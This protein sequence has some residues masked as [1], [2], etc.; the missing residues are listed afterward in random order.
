V[1]SRPW[2]LINPW[3]GGGTA[4]RVRLADA[5]R[6]AGITVHVLSRGED[7]T[8]L[9]RAAVRAGAD[10]LGVAGG[11]GSLGPIAA[12]AIEADVPFVCIPAGT[13]NHFA[14]DLGL[15][16]ADPIGALAAFSGL[17]RWIDTAMVGDRVFLN[18]VSIGAYADV[19]AQ[20][21][22]RERKLD[23]ARV[24]LRRIVRGE[25]PAAAI[26]FRDPMGTE[27]RNVAL[28]MVANNA[29]ALRRAGRFGTRG[30]L[31]AGALQVSVLRTRSGAGLARALLGALTAPPS[32]AAAWTQWDARDL[33][34]DSD[35]PVP[36][37]VD[38]ESIL[39]APP[40][41]LRSRPRSLRV[42]IPMHATHVPRAPALSVRT[43][44]V[45]WD[46]ARQVRVCA[47]PAPWGK[48]VR[49]S[50]S[51]RRPTGGSSTS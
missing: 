21:E 36:A 39:L 17:E 5:A 37:G 47:T 51:N 2:L 48:H 45:L 18:N 19:V 42:L 14:G 27:Q 20:P 43:V 32:A 29:Y 24:T 31:D 22:Y 25:Q 10:A 12:V 4:E 34:I 13:R 7:T 35:E 26:A 44:G 6:S 15:D 40:V 30:R 28:L 11:D 50:T 33:C 41:R 9:A 1:R 23:T 49:C 16:R 38:G 8:A 3:S 46:R